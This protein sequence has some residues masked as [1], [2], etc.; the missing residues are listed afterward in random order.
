MVIMK[1]PVGKLER[2]PS[3]LRDAEPPMN[4][5]GRAALLPA[6]YLGGAENRD[7]LALFGCATIRLQNCLSQG[8]Q[9]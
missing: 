3:L 6:R 7:F 5:V 4:E 9:G 8:D 1:T 2:N